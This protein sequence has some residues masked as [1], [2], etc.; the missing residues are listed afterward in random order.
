MRSPAISTAVAQQ[1]RWMWTATEGDP[2]V[3]NSTVIDQRHLL[4]VNKP[5]SW[6][7]SFSCSPT[8][9]T[10]IE[11]FTAAFSTR[12]TNKWI[13]LDSTE[14]AKR[15]NEPHKYS[16]RICPNFGNPKERWPSAVPC[17]HGSQEVLVCLIT[18]DL[19][20]CEQGHTFVDRKQAEAL[21]LS[22]VTPQSGC[23]CLVK[24]AA[25]RFHSQSMALPLAAVLVSET[26]C[27]L[28][29]WKASHSEGYAVFCQFKINLLTSLKGTD[30][31]PAVTI[32]L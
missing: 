18:V 2:V 5:I 24:G 10:L 7:N 12:Q 17:N 14:I 21:L 31:Q 13:W 20:T 29:D 30:R 3:E 26:G 23:G 15:M 32:H 8:P 27:P 4:L 22:C 9:L 19:L 25:L 1:S 6:E 11:P 16:V 28:C